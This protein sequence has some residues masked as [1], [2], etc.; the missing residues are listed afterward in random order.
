MYLRFAPGSGPSICTNIG[1]DP[2]LIDRGVGEIFRYPWCGSFSFATIRCM[3][4]YK[5]TTEE[6][7]FFPP[8]AQSAV[9]NAPVWSGADNSDLDVICLASSFR[10]IANAGRVPDK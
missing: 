9:G 3:A 7:F 4:A 1:P 6:V 2:A 10:S 8:Y 5:A